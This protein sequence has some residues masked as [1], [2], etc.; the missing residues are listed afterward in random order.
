MS[1]KCK[2]LVFVFALAI[3]KMH[4]LCAAAQGQG[5][6]TLSAR[7]VP[8]PGLPL[9]VTGVFADS[10]PAARETTISFK[11]SNQTGGT[12]KRLKTK[13][14]WL[15]DDKKVLGGQMTTRIL[16]IPNGSSQMIQQTIRIQPQT[17]FDRGEF[18]LVVLEV[19]SES[20][21]WQ[22]TMS[23]KEITAAMK[24]SKPVPMRGSSQIHSSSLV[25][26]TDGSA[27][28]LSASNAALPQGGCGTDFCVQCHILAV[29]DCN[30][31]ILSYHCNGT[32][33]DCSFTCRTDPLARC[34]SPASLNRPPIHSL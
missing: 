18:V 32:T 1:F 22:P 19:S 8:Q 23:N 27:R 6:F 16:D 29:D 9:E 2:S 10:D 14:L 25:E 33:C 17:Y 28:C 30:G 12:L 34:F 24:N 21:A 7:A 31:C 11:L 5:A 26:G 15:D 4:P 20:S 3:A 13:I